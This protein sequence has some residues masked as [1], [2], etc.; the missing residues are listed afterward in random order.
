M[1]AQ[2]PVRIGDW[3]PWLGIDPETKKR[4]AIAS[5]A[6][7]RAD[8]AERAVVFQPGYRT[9]RATYGRHG[10]EVKWLLRGPKGVTQF[11][12]FS[13]WEPGLSRDERH[14]S[15]PM[16]A[17]VGYHALHPQYEGA[18]DGEECEY[19]DGR[20]CFYDGSG[21]AADALLSRFLIEG[22]DVIW[23]T[24]AARHDALTTA[25]DPR[26]EATS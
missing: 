18:P 4:T 19:L 9:D 15:A 24:L 8:D 25:D 10:M 14:V 23:R 5:V 13:G 21:L 17:D 12:M 20:L 16:G 2:P 26:A 11:L 22:E 1:S 7:Y 6:W 3:G